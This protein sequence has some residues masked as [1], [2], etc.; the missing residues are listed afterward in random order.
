MTNFQVYKKILPF[1]LIGF[2]IDLLTM[3]VVAAIAIGGFF[4][5]DKASNQGLIGLAIGLVIGIIIAVLVKLFIT[6]IYKAGM[7]AMMTRGVTT[8]DL[9]DNT[10][11]EGRRVVKERFV[12]IFAFMA[13]TGAIKGVFRQ[14]GNLLNR[15]GTAV[16]GD[17]GNSITSA[18]NAF[19]QV[20]ISYLC[21]CCLGWVFYRKDKNT[22]SAA[23]EGAAIFF[24]HGKTLVRNMGR[25]FGMGFV[26]FLVIGGILT[27]AGFG[28]CHSFPNVFEAL[29]NEIVEAAQRGE[30]EVAEIFYNQQFLMFIVSFVVA[31]FLWNIIH[32]LFIKP[33]IQTGV[34]RNFMNSGIKDMPTEAEMADI[35]KK[36][37]KFANLRRRTSQ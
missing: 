5:A 32:G 30:I 31:V 25:I 19:I 18:I 4:I 12:S 23:C 37:S 8:G 35:E 7:I 15:L 22:A 11:A 1:S 16:G 21:D 20:L 6:N 26:S 9:P 3:I 36:S 13:I 10:L 2:L 28:I 14:L 24:K 27:G 17:V 34:I 33:F 29:A